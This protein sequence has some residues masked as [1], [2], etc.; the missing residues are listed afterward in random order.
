[1]ALV[2]PDS[3]LQTGPERYSCAY[4]SGLQVSGAGSAEEGRASPS[5]FRETKRGK[6]LASGTGTCKML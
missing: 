3:R 4:Y 6:R 5:G 1:V 2:T